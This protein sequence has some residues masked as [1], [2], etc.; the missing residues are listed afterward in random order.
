VLLLNAA[1][2][3]LA[4]LDERVARMLPDARVVHIEGI[5][6]QMPSRIPERYAAE[7]T[8]FVTA[9]AGA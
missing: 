3:P 2:D 4:Y 8:E 6:G 9:T 7:I 5:A 1:D